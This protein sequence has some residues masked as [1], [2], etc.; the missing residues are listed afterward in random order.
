MQRH[1]SAAVFLLPTALRRRFAGA[2]LLCYAALSNAQAPSPP[3]TLEASV[4]HESISSP[5]VRVSP[6]GPLLRVE[7]LFKLSGNFARVAASGA[8][9]W[10]VAGDGH[11]VL[12]G[13]AD[14]KESPS[15]PDL[16]FGF[17]MADGVLTWPAGGW[18][19]G[20]GPTVR[21]LWVAGDFFR[22]SAG[23]QAN[24]LKPKPDGGYLGAFGDF[25]VN[26]HG[27][28]NRDLNNRAGSVSSQ[29][30]VI[31]PGA[32]IDALDLQAGLG[33]ELNTEG[34]ADLSSRSAFWRLSLEHKIAG[35]EWSIGA[36]AVYSR[37]DAPLMDELP[38]RRD[39]FRTLEF[40]VA[41]RFGKQFAVHLE[42]QSG[43]NKSNIPLYENRTQLGAVGLSLTY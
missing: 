16:G 42:L 43:R 8:H 21:R 5:L 40:G 39:A 20:A 10:S 30:R 23:L 17:V 1:P 37:F 6:N 36:M 41:R 35:L 29:W 11:F 15:A 7:G 2:L 28:E 22:D 32:G 13:R 31:R 19:M 34:L 18:T 25:A 14:W 38:V 24:V 27:E 3:A 26:R 4:G 33:R 9:D 12:S